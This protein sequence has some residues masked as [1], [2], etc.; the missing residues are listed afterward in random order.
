MERNFTKEDTNA[1][2]GFAIV[3]M[4]F[5]HVYPN[6]TY[7]PVNRIENV[8]VLS[9]IAAMGKICVALLTLLSGYGLAESYS[10]QSPTSVLSV[11]A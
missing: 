4:V 10:K 6:I 8:T 5:H 11:S 9:V 7:I 1:L 2:K 3:C